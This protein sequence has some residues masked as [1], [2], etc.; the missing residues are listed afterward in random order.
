[1][2]QLEGLIN[3]EK[4][5]DLLKK[6]L[7]RIVKPKKFVGLAVEDSGI[8]VAD[9]HREKDAFNVLDAKHFLFSEGCD[10]RDPEKLGKELGAFLQKNRFSGRKAIIGVPAKWVMMR[11]KTFP[12]SSK[13]SISGML[14]IYAER[15]F[16]LSPEELALDYTTFA[17]DDKT[18]RIV[19][20][21]MLRSN[22]E[23]V[24]LAVRWAGL[25]IY[26]VTVSSVA[27]FSMIRKKMAQPGPAYFL[28]VRPDFAEF[29]ARDGEQIVDVKSFQK[30]I[31]KETEGFI[32]EL[33]RLMAYCS[34]GSDKTGK[35][36]LL[37]WNASGDPARDELKMLTDSLSSQIKIVDGDR[38]AIAAG[39]GFPL[40]EKAY[41]LIAPAMVGQFF[42][43]GDPFRIDF[44]NTRMNLKAG[45]IKKNHVQWAA[46]IS[47]AVLVLLL[48]MFFSWRSD[49][50]DV[51]ELKAKLNDMQGDID[52][53]RDVINK[54]ASA[55][56]WY[57]D[58]PKVLDCLK[59]L[60]A[61]FPEEGKIWVTNLAFNEKMKGVI[62]GRANDEQS[63]IDVLDRMKADHVFTDVQM[64]YLQNNSKSS[65]EVSFSIDFS[66][67]Q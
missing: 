16:S 47:A 43:G 26:S 4:F 15:E 55:S 27:L 11:E 45:T 33:R 56:S 58:R 62:S 9:V 18:S 5:T 28:Y 40:E 38:Q 50:K 12:A 53:A 23:Q 48:V 39:L 41:G 61:A 31:K 37:I 67:A 46:G 52:S 36:Q 6:R 7:G 32:T 2:F 25:G 54:V 14:N 51:N 8:L 65:Q 29:L 19:L 42:N 66:F 34:S 22:M 60:T 10:L 13:E 49:K 35:E 30:G 21:A 59:K 64:I 57:S 24:M 1:M 20:S 17:I 63:I 44:L 3:L